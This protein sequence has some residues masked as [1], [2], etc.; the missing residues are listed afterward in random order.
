MMSQ[1]S[2]LLATRHLIFSEG[3][4]VKVAAAQFCEKKAANSG[5]KPKLACFLQNKSY[6]VVIVSGDI[7]SE[8]QDSS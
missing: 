4:P 2:S 7:S 1:Y 5:K 3:K 6:Q 8:I